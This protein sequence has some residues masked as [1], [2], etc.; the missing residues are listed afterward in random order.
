MKR[1]TKIAG[2][3]IGMVVSLVENFLLELELR[4]LV[5]AL[6]SKGSKTLALSRGASQ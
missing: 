4:R 3:L 1:S 6:A 2:T 5:P